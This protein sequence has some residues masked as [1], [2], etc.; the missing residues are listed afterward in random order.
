MKK[1]TSLFAGIVSAAFMFSSC[2][3][4]SNKD[5]AGGVGPASASSFAGTSVSFNP[6][7]FFFPGGVLEYVNEEEGSIFDLAPG[8]DPLEGTFSYEPSSDFLTGSLIVRL[9]GD[10]ED[11]ILE[12][13]NFETNDQGL[14]VGFTITLDGVTYPA[15]VL[16]GSLQAAVVPNTG[17]GGGGGGGGNNDDFTLQENGNLAPGTKFSRSFLATNPQGD[18]SDSPLLDY[19]TGESVEFTIAANGALTFEGVDGQLSLP[20]VASG[21]GINSY[22]AQVNGGVLAATLNVSGPEA[23]SDFSIIWTGPVDI[24]NPSDIIVDNKVFN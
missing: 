19:G 15:T 21:E 12:L 20:F 4:D 7:L 6:T 13:S 23:E 3:S 17:G 5:G 1:I 11:T 16:T 18:V 14:I 2:S 8:D 24:F 22:Q 9:S 10:D